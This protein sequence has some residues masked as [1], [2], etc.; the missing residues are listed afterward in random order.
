MDYE[1]VEDR[2]GLRLSWNV[3]AGSRIESTRTVVPI[4]AV[5]LSLPLFFVLHVYY[6][7][8]SLLSAGEVTERVPKPLGPHSK[9]TWQPVGIV[10]A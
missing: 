7:L 5:S 9:L 2:D 4:A 6:K 1:S 3:L 8:V 10:A